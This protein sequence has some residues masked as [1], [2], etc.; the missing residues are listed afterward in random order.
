M[1]RGQQKA[2]EQSSLLFHCL[3]LKIFG[4]FK[5]INFNS[6]VDR[7]FPLLS[8]YGIRMRRDGCSVGLKGP[9]PSVPTGI[10]R[11]P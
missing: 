7:D 4:S 11:F 10:L 3:D 6:L 2:T 5:M 8:N 1:G 9:V